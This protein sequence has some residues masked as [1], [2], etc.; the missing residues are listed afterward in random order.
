MAR[1]SPP[2]GVAP[3]RGTMIAINTPKRTFRTRFA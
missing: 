1:I 2:K 3:A